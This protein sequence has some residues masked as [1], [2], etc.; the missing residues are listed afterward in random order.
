MRLLLSAF[1]LMLC[2]LIPACSSG[3]T[4]Y[5]VKGTLLNKE[6]PYTVAKG[7]GVTIVFIPIVAATAAFDTYP[8]RMDPDDS[9]FTVEGKEGKGMPPGKYRVSIQQMVPGGPA[10]IS[11]MNERFSD[12]N[13]PIIVEITDGKAPLVIDLAKP[14]G[15]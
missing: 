15:K 14:A 8:T 10:A 13:T 3:P 9:S 2:F 11:E 6:K 5:K 1:G 4:T 12:K 7:G